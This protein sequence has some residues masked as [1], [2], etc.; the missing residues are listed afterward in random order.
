MV[1]DLAPWMVSTNRQLCFSMK[2]PHSVD[3]VALL[4]KGTHRFPEI[5]VDIFPDLWNRQRLFLTG[6]LARLH[7][8]V[9]YPLKISVSQ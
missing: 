2:K 1:L 3:S 4:P 6:I 8:G 9:F 7:F 5:R